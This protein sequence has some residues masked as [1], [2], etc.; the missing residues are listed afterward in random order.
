M[1]IFTLGYEGLSV[2]AFVALLKSAKIK[3]VCDAREL[4][5]SRK[6]GFSKTKL[7]ATLR[8]ADIEYTHARALGCPSAIRRR[9]KSDRDWG[10]YSRAF[11]QH[12]RKKTA[13]VAELARSARTKR[14]CVIC[15]EADF[16]RCH[17]SI[18]ASAAARKANQRVIH[19]SRTM[20]LA[21]AS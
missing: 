6:R 10:T 2:E 9:Y 14:S 16:S 4:P 20:T 11:R 3:S 5:L 7:A 19:L 1:A 18:V 8:R 21:S 12:L 17:R 13:A 15:F